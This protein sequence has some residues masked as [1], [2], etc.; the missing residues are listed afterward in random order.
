MSLLYVLAFQDKEYSGVMRENGLFLFL[1]TESQE[2]EKEFSPV[3]SS[4]TLVLEN[5]FQQNLLGTQIH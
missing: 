3:F 4:F 1:V 2:T 5:L